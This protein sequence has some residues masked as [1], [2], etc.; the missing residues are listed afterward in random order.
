MTFQNHY[1]GSPKILQLDSGGNPM[2]WL[3]IEDYAT[4]K[5]KERVLW[6][7]GT[8]AYT[9][10]GGTNAKTG[11]RS[12][13]ML[14]TIVAIKHEGKVK[15]AKRHAN[16]FNPTLSNKMLFERDKYLCAYC[17]HVYPKHK[18]TRDHIIPVSKNGSDDWLNVITACGPCNRWKDNRT[19]EEAGLLLLMVPYK[20]SFHEHL[21]LKNRNILYDQLEFLLKGVS[22]DSPV[23]KESILRLAK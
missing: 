16:G 9:M 22:P 1:D 7:T 18:L 4:L 8:Y 15:T 14:D 12:E 10:R 5:A 23:Y 11:M 3:S 2:D 20:P 17:G 21:I 13:L 19:P 6:T